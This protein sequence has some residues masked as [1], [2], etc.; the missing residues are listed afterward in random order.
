MFPKFLVVGFSLV[1]AGFAQSAPGVCGA[2]A[3]AAQPLAVVVTYTAGQPMQ[4][5][6]AM[7]TTQVVQSKLVVM[8]ASI[9]QGHPV[10]ATATLALGALAQDPASASVSSSVATLA[11]TSTLSSA[12]APSTQSGSP[13]RGTQEPT[14]KGVRF[15]GGGAN[16]YTYEISG[17]GFGNSMPAAAAN[18]QPA[19]L[20]AAAVPEC[21]AFDGQG[22]CS[23]H[24]VVA[25][26]ES[27]Q[28]VSWSDT[29]ITLDMAQDFT[30]VIPNSLPL[31]IGIT[32]PGAP[33]TASICW[34]E[35]G[36]SCQLGPVSSNR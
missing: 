35:H 20:I 13:V 26:A 12:S 25:V 10:V 4:T 5:A 15:M 18:G 8:T 7:A 2:E 32:V 28:I 30:R 1:A 22:S 31:W 24:I 11:S 21:A 23:N 3:T 33:D 17:Q 19:L 16:C 34:A 14:I 9:L 29:L 36:G 27:F 6:A